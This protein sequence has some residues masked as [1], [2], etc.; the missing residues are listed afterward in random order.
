MPVLDK[1]LAFYQ[2]IVRYV[3]CR[4]CALGLASQKHAHVAWL[5][6]QVAPALWFHFCRLAV[7]PCSQAQLSHT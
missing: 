7:T 3:V 5:I 1:P 4:R 6:G 2:H